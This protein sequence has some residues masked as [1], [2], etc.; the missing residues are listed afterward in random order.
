ME[1]VSLVGWIAPKKD[2]GTKVHVHL[3]ASM[4]EDE[5][6]VTMGGHLNR[7]TICGIKVAVAILEIEPK[8]VR[9]E[10]D[11]DTRSNDIFFGALNRL[12]AD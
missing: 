8:S 9:A 7:E 11:P 5:T 3:S 1:L 12:S 10:W 6:V 2:D 4:V